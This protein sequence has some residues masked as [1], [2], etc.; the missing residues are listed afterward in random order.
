MPSGGTLVIDGLGLDRAPWWAYSGAV[1]REL[2][3]A[4]VKGGAEAGRSVE[5]PV[6]EKGQG[7]ERQ[8]LR[9]GGYGTEGTR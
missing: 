6:R 2:W 4:G 7:E 5:G 1:T 3:A 8:T 9:G